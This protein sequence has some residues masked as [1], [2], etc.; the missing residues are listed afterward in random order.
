MKAL[1]DELPLLQALFLRGLGVVLCLTL[2][3]WALGQL[4]FALGA[5]NWT[6]I[7]LRAAAEVGGAYFFLTALF[8]MPIA[9]LSAILQALPLTVSLA[10]A[11]F[12]GEALGWRRLTAILIGFGGVLLI[13]QPGA[14]GFTIYALYGLAA[15]ACITARDLTVRRMSRD[16]PS[17]LVAL[18]AA[19][20]VTAF[21][22]AGAALIDWAPITPR[23]GTQ[24]LAAMVF[25]IFGYVFS[26][27]AMR[28]GDIA[29]IAPFRYTSLLVALLVGLVVF[30]EFPGPLALAGAALVVATGLFTL[31][32]EARLGRARRQIAGRLR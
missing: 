1:A 6:L 29:F 12:L 26:V 22:G 19:V 31:Y 20:G 25:V 16:V 30:S 14:D 9:N 21:A 24:L 10:G 2:L 32:R 15:V 27:A 8:N 18:A 17:V 5:R 11:L 13:V 4:R 23:A 7:W 28:T 3:C